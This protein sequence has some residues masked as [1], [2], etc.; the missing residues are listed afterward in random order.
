MKNLKFEIIIAYYKRPKI[1]LNA[2]NSILNSTYT[3]WHLSFIDDSGDELFKKTLFN[4]GFNN[5]KVEY[6]PILM[7]DSEKS[8]LGGSIHGKY[9]NEVIK[10][11]DSDIIII[12]CDDDALE[13]S[14]MENLNTFFNLNVN[15]VWCYSHVKFFNPNIESYLESSNSPNDPHLNPSSLNSYTVPIS[16]A[17]KVDSAQVVFKRLAYTDKDIWYPFPSTE[18]LDAYIFTRMFSSWGPCKFTGII[19]QYKGWFSDQLGI[20]IRQGKGNFM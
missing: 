12:L 9:M 6:V 7:S 2:L 10:K 20:R 4:F 15:E 1:V 3:N 14:Y 13:H 19:G 11:T 8:S 17:Y 16:P 5:D 18:N